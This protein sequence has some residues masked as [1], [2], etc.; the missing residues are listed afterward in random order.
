MKEQIGFESLT[1]LIA[2]ARAGSL[3]SYTAAARALSV[4]PS[5]VSKNIQRLE[6]HLGVV[7]FTR[8][9][10]SITLTPEGRDL[11]E[12]VLRLL[13]DAEDIEQA[14]KRARAQPGGTVRIAASLPVG[15]H[16]LA[17]LLPLFR[18][19][20]PEVKI[21]LRLGDERVN[22]IEEGVDIAIRIGELAD[23]SLLSRRLSPYQLGCYASPDYLKRCGE[24]QHP[25]EL[26]NHQTVNLIY[27]STGQLFRW[28]FTIGSR[29]VEIQPSSAIVTDASEAVL[30][31]VAAGAGIGMAASFM[32]ASWAERGA[33]VPVLAE[34]AT[35]RHNLTALWPESRRA[36]PA[37][38]AFLDML[39]EL[40]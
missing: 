35:E 36:N 38:R 27:K 39:F 26:V 11:H 30:V 37:V 28:P 4:S 20:Q 23:S 34:F 13:R 7:L 31:S 6:Q 24:P 8:T 15:V 29:E 1:G 22:V 16:L 3:G 40:L 19:R 14:A 5:S 10:R 12:R 25:D 18:Q 9:T 33:L 21:D 32:A 17:P 2:F